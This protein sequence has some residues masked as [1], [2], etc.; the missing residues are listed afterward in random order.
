MEKNIRLKFTK[1]LLTLI[2]AAVFVFSFFYLYEGYSLVGKTFSGFGIGTQL[3]FSPVSDKSWTGYNSGIQNYDRIIA[4]ENIKID[5]VDQFEKL[6]QKK[7]PY[8]DVKYTFVRGNKTYD[9]IVKTMEFSFPV[10]IT[11]YGIT[12][13][14]S[15][16]YLL[17]AIFIIINYRPNDIKIKSLLAFCLFFAASVSSFHNSEFIHIFAPID[18]LTQILT[19]SCLVQLGLSI[20]I[21][22]LKKSKYN[23]FSVLNIVISTILFFSIFVLSSVTIRN[24]YEYSGALE[25][26][27]SVFNFH[28]SFIA[29]S[30]L[31]FAILISYSY[32]KSPN[33][34]LEKMQNRVILTGSILS[35]SPYFVLWVIPTIFGY[36]SSFENVFI[37]FILLPVF[38]TYSIVKYRA[39]DIEFFIRKGLIYAS[40]S[41]MLVFGYFSI[42]TVGFLLLRNILSL[43]QEVYIAA[44]AII[45]TIMAGKLQGVIQNAIDKAFYRHKLNLTILLEE[46]INEIVNSFDKK[47]LVKTSM[48]YLE[49]TI[50]PLFIGLYIPDQNRNQLQLLGTNNNSLPKSLDLPHEVLSNYKD[51]DNQSKINY[52]FK[53][54]SVSINNAMLLPLQKDNDTIGILVLGE[55]KSETD[56]LFEEKNF[57]KNFTTGLSMALNSMILKEE[58]L[59]LAIKNIELE[60]KAQFLRQLTANLSHDLKFPLSSAYSI[61]NKMKYAMNKKSSNLNPEFFE[62]NM[63][64]LSK[65]LKKIGEYISISL[66]REL[67]SLGKLALKNEEVNIKQTCKDA[68]FLHSDYL[69]KNNIALESN[70]DEEA[71]YILGDAIRLESVI[72][73]LI[74]NAI[75]YGGDKIILNINNLEKKIIIEVADNGP[76]IDDSVKQNVFDCYVKGNPEE[77][78][79]SGKERST[80]L[81]LFICKNYIEMM[82]GS[83]WFESDKN[84]TKFFIELPIMINDT[85]ASYQPPLEIEE[86]VN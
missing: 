29:V 80:G 82:N 56:Y 72:S 79:N 31:S 28:I 62:G 30:F 61:V 34:S 9:A 35:F 44:S 75:K 5:S 11:T 41:T 65:S 57:L 32:F 78:I 50:N 84:G 6:I 73:N 63:S 83:I 67:I 15:L 42:S 21:K 33:H 18:Y 24:V 53:N 8:T 86:V 74:S 70:F 77:G 10:F 43:N 69:R 38:I 40:L 71:I 46:F 1:A 52:F 17:T 81:G 36:G 13:A 59:S 64:D 51:T 54:D 55:K 14:I 20:N 85:L 66:D 23:T 27:L 12:F 22:N 39:F 26:Y 68:I 45:A 4:V 3:I 58:K 48:F 37:G 7:T 47:D 2:T 49:K 25:A 16:F 19:V 60:S 76:G